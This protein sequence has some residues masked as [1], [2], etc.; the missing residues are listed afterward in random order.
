MNSPIQ[1][2]EEGLLLCPMCRWDATHLE[3]VRVAARQ[4]DEKPNE[5][6]VNALTGQI[7]T[8]G[9][10]P[11]PAGQARGVGRR[12]RVAVTGFCEEAG[13]RFAIVFT[14]HK[15]GTFVE[16]VAPITHEVEGDPDPDL[17]QT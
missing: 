7:N 2:D 3:I 14:Q 1:V 12:Q 15:G 11:A 8:H 16:V 5:I 10:E 9:Q 17:P 13:H 6:V 4:E